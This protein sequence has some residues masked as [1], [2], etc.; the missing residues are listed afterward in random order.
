LYGIFVGRSSNIFDLKER[1]T[2]EFGLQQQFTKVYEGVGRWDEVE[3][4]PYLVDIPE[5]DGETILTVVNTG[6]PSMPFSDVLRDP[7]SDITMQAVKF[8]NSS[9]KIRPWLDWSY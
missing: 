2:R 3:D 4:P 8:V 7:L 1:I 6:K 9:D 5:N